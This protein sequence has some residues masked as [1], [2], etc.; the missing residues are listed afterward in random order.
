MQFLYPEIKSFI[1][2]DIQRRIGE[3]NGID[4]IVKDSN[5]DKKRRI[6][7]NEAYICQLIRSDSI[8]EFVAFINQTIMSKKRQN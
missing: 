8:E 3:S 6:G 2:D 4:E 7:E 1:D 5:F